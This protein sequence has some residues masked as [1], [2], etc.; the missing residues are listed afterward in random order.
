MSPK[1]PNPSKKQKLSALVTLDAQTTCSQLTLDAKTACSQVTLDTKT[2]CSVA[3]KETKTTQDCIICEAEAACST[4]I[5]DVEAWR[6]PRLR[7]SKGN[8]ATSCGIW[9]EKSSKRRAEAKL[10]SSP[11]ARPLCTPA[12]WS[13]GV[14]RQLPT[15]SY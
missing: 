7:H 2:T 12:R 1:Q 4:A 5:R 11:P 3:V 8:M 6:A 13:S 14:L 15:T 10:T 9:R